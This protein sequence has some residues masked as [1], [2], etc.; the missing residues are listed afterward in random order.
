V[1]ALAVLI[2]RLGS[3]IAATRK[4]PAVTGFFRGFIGEV[5][6]ITLIVLAL[7]AMVF[8]AYLPTRDDWMLERF[9]TE[10]VEREFQEI[11]EGRQG[12]WIRLAGPSL[13]NPQEK[14]RSDTNCPENRP[15]GVQNEAESV[16]C[17]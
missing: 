11:H 12:L 10:Q 4:E 13:R 17:E 1:I 6:A 15:R 8:A 9:P 3:L 16:L 2:R 5:L 14:D 7:G